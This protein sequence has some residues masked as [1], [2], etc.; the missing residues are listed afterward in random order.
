MSLARL[1][2]AHVLAA[3]TLATALAVGCGGGGGGSDLA[4]CGNGRLDGG[5][6]CDDGNLADDDACL[7]TCEAAVCGDSYLNRGAEECDVGILPSTCE[8]LGFR[9]GTVACSSSCRLDTSGC[10]GSGGPIPTPVAS[11]TPLATASSGGPTATAG[12]AT[13]TPTPQ[14]TPTGATCSGSESI[15]VVVALDDIVTSARIDV[16]YPS[17]ANVPGTGTDPA[18]KQR[19]TFA[20]SGLTVVNDFDADGDL[21]DDTLTTSLVGTDAVPAG[22]FVT[23]T[24]DCIAGAPVPT[25]ADFTCTVVSASNAGTAVTPACSV[26]IQ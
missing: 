4:D 10:T 8:S 22:P 20:G 6:A 15:A 3:V 26:T 7:S 16:A 24:F 17:S 18:V 14:S 21:A 25:A 1:R 19:V 11:A 9:S 23:V 12:V 13:D 5:E 2:C